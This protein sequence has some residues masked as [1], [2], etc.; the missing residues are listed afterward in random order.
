MNRTCKTLL[1]ALLAGT[2]ITQ[3]GLVGAGELPTGATTVYGGVAISTPSANQMTIQQTT[4][5]A[6]VN[7]QGFSVGAGNRVDINQP[8]ASSAILNRVTG[9][10]TSTIAGQINANGQ[11]YL[12]NP[13]G[14][15][16]TSSG[17][18]RAGAFVASTLDISDQDFAS[19]KRTFRGNGQSAAVSN[20]G[21]I[22][23][24]RGGYA[25]L[26]GGK[27]DNSGVISVPMG[28]V[29][30][31]AGE[32]AT[33]DFSGDGFLQ[34]AIPSRDDGSDRALIQHSGRISAPGG[35]VVMQV[36]TARAAARNA[37]NL[38][39]IIEAHSIGGRN[40]AIVLGGG[41]G[42]TV[43]VSGRLDVSARAAVSRHVAR[44]TPRQAARG[45]DITVTGDAIRLQGAAL[46]ADGQ[47]G[48]GTIRVGGGFQGRG[49]LQRAS[50][51]SV[52]AATTLS[53][54]AGRTGNGGDVVVWSDHRTAFTGLISATGGAQGG[55]GGQAEVSSK[56]VLAYD[57][58][59]I[60]TAAKGSFGTLLL[61]PYNVTISTGTDTN[62][63]GFAATGNDSVINATT[64]Q[65][66]LR[67]ANVTVTTGGSGSAGSQAGDITVAAP[68]IWGT[69]NGGGQT[70]LTLSASRSI[71]VNSPLTVSGSGGLV[72]NTR[73]GDGSGSLSFGPSGRASFTGSTAGQ[74]LT[75][76]DVP[77]TIINNATN[78]A[79]LFRPENINGRFAIASDLN[80]ADLAEFGIRL[81]P[82]GTQSAP[83]GGSLE[84]LGHTI[85]GLNITS[86]AQY[87]GLFGY[88]NGAIIEN[89]RL[90][91]VNVTS[92]YAGASDSFVGGLVGF[93]TNSTIANI[94]INGTVTSGTAPG[95]RTFAHTG[96]LLGVN[97]GSVTGSS[98]GGTVRGGG[99]TES[100]TG[101]LVGT[102]QD[103][104]SIAQSFSTANVF[105]GSASNSST[106]TGGLIGWNTS[107]GTVSQVYATGAVTGGAGIGGTSG[108]YT[109]GLIGRVEGAG[110]LRQAYATGAVQGGNAN[111]R[112]ATGGLL[113]YSTQSFSQAY[114]VGRVTAGTGPNV[115][116]GGLVGFVNS[117]TAS[118]SF[119]DTSTTGQGAATGNNGNPAGT[120]PLT[121][122]QFQNAATF[123][124]LASSQGWDFQTTWSPPT[125]S[126][127]PQLYSIS[128]GA[129]TGT[130]QTPTTDPATQANNLNNARVTPNITTILPNFNVAA[131]SLAD[132]LELNGG[133]GPTLG[134]GQG[135]TTGDGSS[136]RAGA[137][138]AL[139]SVQRASNLLE[140]RLAACD[141]KSG[142]ASRRI[143][144]CYSDALG[145]F[146]DQLDIQ[147]QQ[148]PPAFRGLPA[149]IR[150]AAQQVKAARTVAEARAAVAVAVVAV[151]KAI[152]LLRADEPAVTR[153]QLR[154]GNAIASALRTVDSRLSRAVGL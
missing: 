20:Q 86:A 69:G 85:S 102:N 120:T 44:S 18:V 76:N 152:S 67:S 98:F 19:G 94:T 128:G 58:T 89:L 6:I 97:S 124:P 42:G 38:S 139:N 56:G 121:T 73:Q 148:L 131:L 33:L 104:G 63:T 154:Q 64:L 35:Q 144:N 143:A 49:T 61:D 79:L 24:Q 125:A 109:G 68:V 36:A 12:V 65:N 105:G 25:A 23:I 151:R 48:G 71:I 62:P 90:N 141:S 134:L 150:Q 137:Q 13:N 133:G 93:A 37:I 78:F 91:N 30:L 129:P 88:A 29:G 122:A 140:E 119:W 16:I 138:S 115:S 14:I 92:T 54:N 43:T 57:G 111:G 118:A 4:P 112:S 142:S 2:A 95:S 50:T 132:S 81:S 114:A 21:T 9:S 26:L 28:R 22:E 107:S 113:G 153:I 39:G 74:S 15:A 17:T 110:P 40:G 5:T 135:S 83:F 103:A 101:G 60:L 51:T 77:Y 70:I 52:D 11:I 136:T 45:G 149:V 41:D 100:E 123:V 126:S 96:G 127:Y 117:G 47:A 80:A 145:G 31:G 7:W 82:I 146:A 87:V 3:P 130:G 32:Q 53:A 1:Q 27:V 59:T 84:G 10:A 46:L 106:D 66:A 108:S 75:I 8:S 147:L 55:N 116:T 99:G 72:L 34:V